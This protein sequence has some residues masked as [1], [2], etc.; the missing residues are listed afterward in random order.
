MHTTALHQGSQNLGMSHYSKNVFSYTTEMVGLVYLVYLDLKSRATQQTLWN[1]SLI[2]FENK[3][4][5]FPS[6][7]E[8]F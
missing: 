7:L 4:L 8:N 1:E 6:T 5:H 3:Y 2:L